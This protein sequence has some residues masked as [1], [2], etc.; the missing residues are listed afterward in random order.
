MTV[1]LSDVSFKV[2]CSKFPPPTL[3]IEPFDYAAQ[4]RPGILNRK[5]QRMPR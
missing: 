2:Q 3:N 4:G 5:A 1:R